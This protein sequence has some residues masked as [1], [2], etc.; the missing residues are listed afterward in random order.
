MNIM[1]DFSKHQTQRVMDSAAAMS[2]QKYMQQ[3]D[4]EKLAALRESLKGKE[5]SEP[6]KDAHH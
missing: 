4:A 2:I 5:S 3:D 6:L 1:S